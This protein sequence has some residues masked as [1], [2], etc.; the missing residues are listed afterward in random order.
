MTSLADLF[1]LGP[2]CGLAWPAPPVCILQQSTT[3]SQDAYLSP[4]SSGPSL[5][6]LLSFLFYI[7]L[8]VHECI[9][10]IT[11]GL[12][13]KGEERVLN[14]EG[15]RRHYKYVITI[16]CLFLGLNFNQSLNCSLII[17]III[18]LY[19]VFPHTKATSSV[20]FTRCKGQKE[21]IP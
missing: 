10:I 3:V 17:I 8:L 6:Y 19:S 5:I 20:F 21:V 9:L 13:V 18:G 2:G 15:I 16:L 11:Q 1:Y 14:I 12:E 4:L 7:F